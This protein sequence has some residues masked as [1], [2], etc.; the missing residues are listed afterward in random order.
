MQTWPVRFRRLRLPTSG[1][2]IT[3]FAVAAGLA[4]SAPTAT[5][6]AERDG[7]MGR[8]AALDVEGVEAAQIW[9][10]SDGLRIAGFIIRPKA[11]SSP[12]PVLIYNRGGN[13]R[14]SAITESTLTYLALLTA[15]GDGFVVLAS[16]YRGG[17]RSEGVDEFGGADANDV[18]N[19]VGLAR[20]LPY[21]DP[22]RVFM[23]GVSRGGLMTYRAL[24]ETGDVR[25]AAVIGGVAD[26]RANYRERPDMRHILDEL[27]GTSEE[28][29]SARSPVEWAERITTPVIILHGT[30]D[31]RVDVNHG[32]TMAARLAEA[33]REHKLLI[34]PGD[35]HYL[36]RN[37]RS[38]E[39]SIFAWF[40]QHDA[41]AAARGFETTPICARIAA[42]QPGTPTDDF[43]AAVLSGDEAAVLGYLSGGADPETAVA[44]RHPDFARGREVTRNAI[45]AAA[46]LGHAGT[47]RILLQG[48]ASIDKR[49]NAFAICSAVA[50]GHAEVVQVL[51]EAGVG[52]SERWCGRGGRLTALEMAEQ[53]GQSR[54]V[55][56][57]RG[58]GD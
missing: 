8:C 21:V 11:Q 4:A 50:A 39:D 42:V 58:A 10:L 5:T 53:T 7:Q 34:Y 57:L 35:D 46:A 12:L 26:L 29:F 16:Q 17:P 51:I 38:A 1:L 14:F 18:V 40:S 3:F 31:E 15:R 41:P 48:G 54:I 44:F 33:G 49:E 47:V 6:S 45:V 37:R 43:A 55:E 28:S 19:L 30:A 20:A 22:E 36:S 56:M 32:R 52:G 2:F 13:R 25:A 24:A 9:Y 27:V 23:L